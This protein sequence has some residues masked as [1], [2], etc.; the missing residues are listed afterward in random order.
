MM[1][2][3]NSERAILS[4]TIFDPAR[5]EDLSGLLSASDF[6]LPFHAYLYQAMG[7]LHAEE[8]P[9]EETFL[10]TKLKRINKF[11]EAAFMDVLSANPI[12]NIDAYSNAIIEYAKLRSLAKLGTQLRKLTIEDEQASEEVVS[13]AAKELEIISDHGSVDDFGSVSEVIKGVEDRM[14]KASAHKEVIGYKSG[15]ITL[16]LKIEA[17]EPGK[18]I[19]IAARPSMGKTSLAT[20]IAEHNLSQGIGVLFDSLEMDRHDIM[21]RLLSAKSDETISDLKRGV[22]K[23]TQK[24]QSAKE[25]YYKSPLF[26]HD[27]SYLTVEQLK[28]KALRIFRK[29]PEVKLWILDHARYIKLHGDNVHTE[30]GNIVK[31]LKK[32]AKDHQV[33]LFLLS[34]INRLNENRINKKPQLSDLRDSGAIEEDAD[35]VIMLHRDSYYQR[36]NNEREAPVNEAD[37]LVLKN[38][39]GASGVCKCF[40]DGPHSTFLNHNYSV[41]NTPKTYEYTEEIK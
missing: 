10:E 38:R 36:S 3:L 33:T 41:S 22:V 23:N 29:H 11:D 4:A 19:V 40:F 5:Y 27:K 9:I 1:Y 18:L 28:A 20:V 8:Q 31:E 34:Q 14:E 24:F 30:V 25:F 16:D 39:D 6:Y 12:T 15:L 32:V 17:F 7:E 35:M 2:N 37:I 26:I 13:Y 21:R